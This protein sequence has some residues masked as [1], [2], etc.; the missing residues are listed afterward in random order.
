MDIKFNDTILAFAGSGLHE[1]TFTYTGAQISP[2]EVTFSTKT[3]EGLRTI[4]KNK[5]RAYY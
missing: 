2:L 1:L 5:Y 3:S 4:T